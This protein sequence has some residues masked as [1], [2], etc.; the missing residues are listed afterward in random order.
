MKNYFQ[1]HTISKV[2]LILVILLLVLLIFQA[3]IA[4]GYHRG[5][6]S[7]NRN[8]AYG[9]GMTDPH[10][11]FAPFIHD[12]DGASPHGSI[13]QIVSV[14]LPSLM[15]KGT[16]SAEQ[17]VTVSPTTTIRFIHGTASEKDLEPGDQVIVI[18][19]PQS[20]GSIHASFIRI[21][22]LMSNGATGS[23]TQSY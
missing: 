9:R 3:G 20:N 2:I 1:S 7:V 18:G 17:I 4:V 13:G 21:I 11:I 8:A 16:N 15:I 5:T 12:S 22:S 10:S 14:N 23:S 6:F 19:E